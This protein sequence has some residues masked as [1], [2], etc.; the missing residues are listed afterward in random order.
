MSIDV[1]CDFDHTRRSLRYTP[2]R[3]VREERGM[4]WPDPGPQLH[5][6]IEFGDVAAVYRA[7]RK[8]LEDHKDEPSAADFYYGEME[9]RRLTRPEKRVSVAERLATVGER[10]ILTLYWLVAG[11]GL[12]ASR[13]L[14]AL[15]V[16]IALFAV[17][18]DW[19]VSTA[20]PTG[21]VC[22]SALRARQVSSRRPTI[23]SPNRS[24]K[25][26]N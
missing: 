5:S 25:R 24:A 19:W 3:I 4:R 26:C 13:A 12:R 21:A 11:Y 17:A 14:A 9:M 23:L 6:T 8:A 16:T 20:S 22:S 15:L 7:L 10:S 1:S 18:F 2:R